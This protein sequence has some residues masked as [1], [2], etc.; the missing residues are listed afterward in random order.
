MSAEASGETTI[1]A[2]ARRGGG[3][4]VSPPGDPA[5]DGCVALRLDAAR[6]SESLGDTEAVTRRAV[7]AAL[8]AA[9]VDPAA[10]EL[11]VLLIDD[12]ASQALNARHRGRNAATNVLSW[13]AFS[14]DAPLNASAIDGLAAGAP[15]ALVFLG[16]LAVAFET[17]LREA[18]AQSKSLDAHYSHLIV[19]GV[20]HLLGYDHQ[21]ETDAGAMEATEIA[22]LSAIGVADPYADG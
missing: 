7:I 14:L 11:S 3:E 13:P 17:T 16:D 5:S 21:S 19:H 6:W 1:A 20:L 4:E 22:A 8:E 15:D 18:E 12:N 9:K 10:V 2:E